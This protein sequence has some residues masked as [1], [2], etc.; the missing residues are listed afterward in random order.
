MQKQRHLAAQ[1]LLD[2]TFGTKSFQVGANSNETISL[3]LTSIKAADIGTKRYDL[4]GTTV[5]L[6]EANATCGRHYR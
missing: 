2:G 4:N 6:G 3:G 1:K 5:G